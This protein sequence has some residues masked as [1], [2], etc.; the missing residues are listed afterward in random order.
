MKLKV[1]QIKKQLGVVFPNDL[2]ASLGWEPGD[3]LEFEIDHSRLKVV[4]V[5]TAFEQGIRIAEQAMDDYRGT[6]EAL[7]KS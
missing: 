6:L 1:R 3:I 5:E 4:R 7:A 2:I